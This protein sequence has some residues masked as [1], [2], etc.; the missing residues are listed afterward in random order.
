M[1]TIVD[2]KAGNLTSVRLAFEHLGIPALVTADPAV[3]RKAE[4]LYFPGVGAAGSAMVTLRSGGLVDALREVADRGAPFMGVCL[5]MQILFDR[6]DEDGGVPCLG[7]FPGAVHRFRFDDRLVK[8]PH[9]GWNGVRPLRPH[10]LF[11]GVEPGS[12]FYFVHSYYTEPARPEDRL[13]ETEYGGFAFTSV[14]ARGNIVATQ[15][16]PEK[17]GRIGLK[18]LANFAGWDGQC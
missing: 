9:M 14:A 12:E 8:I 2:Y 13:G 1:I 16:H 3:V 11:A 6:S 10:P 7:L 17:S 5:G 15:F 4:R 18:L